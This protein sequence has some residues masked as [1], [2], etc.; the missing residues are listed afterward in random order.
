[1]AARG[2]DLYNQAANTQ[3]QQQSC[4]TLSFPAAPRLQPQYSKKFVRKELND[5][6]SDKSILGSNG[7][8]FLLVLL[9]VIFAQSDL[10]YDNVFACPA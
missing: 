9:V 3:T 5:A 2:R 10:I 7:K 4:A 6:A 8:T 1:M